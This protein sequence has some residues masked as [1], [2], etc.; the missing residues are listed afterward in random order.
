MAALQRKK[1]PQLKARINRTPTQATAFQHKLDRTGTQEMPHS[2]TSS[3]APERKKCRSR[4][5]G[6]I[7]DTQQDKGI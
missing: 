4:R 5:Q 2:N 1:R 7:H 3:T 6:E